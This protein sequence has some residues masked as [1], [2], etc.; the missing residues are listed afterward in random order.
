MIASAEDSKIKAAV[1]RQTFLNYSPVSN[2]SIDFPDSLLI[3]SKTS[4]PI[5]FS[6]RSM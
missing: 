3:Q 6:P 5:S 1:P 4:A 2:H